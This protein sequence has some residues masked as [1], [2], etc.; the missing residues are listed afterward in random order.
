MLIPTVR[1]TVT[2]TG[3]GSVIVA[4]VADVD[5]PSVVSGSSQNTKHDKN[6]LVSCKTT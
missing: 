6:E 2:E 4:A 3:N 1:E 5:I